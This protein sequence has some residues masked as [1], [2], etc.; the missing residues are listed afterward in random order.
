MSRPAADSELHQFKWLESDDL[1]GGLP[2]K[3][4]HLV[5]VYDYDPDAAIVHY[6][7]GGPYFKD[8]ADCDYADEWNEL[9]RETTF[10][11]QK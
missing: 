5:G 11:A 10:V 2:L 4:N 1:I 7:E 9:L 8:Y 3:W 6:T